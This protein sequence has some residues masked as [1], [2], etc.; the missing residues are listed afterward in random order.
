MS[1]SMKKIKKQQRVSRQEIQSMFKMNM[2]A[3]TETINGM[4]EEELILRT[5]AF[6]IEAFGGDKHVY[7]ALLHLQFRMIPQI[8]RKIRENPMYD[9]NK[10]LENNE[11]NCLVLPYFEGVKLEEA[12]QLLQV[13]LVQIPYLIDEIES[14]IK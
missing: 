14:R 6:E 7:I 3:F 11:N 12:T 8:L 9:F 13:R 1:V 4:I 2:F 5:I 10:E